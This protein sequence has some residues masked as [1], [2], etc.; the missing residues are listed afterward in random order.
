MLN[1]SNVL[2]GDVGRVSPVSTEDSVTCRFL[3][4]STRSRRP[5]ADL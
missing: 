2:I 3:K 5:L 1:G 4:A